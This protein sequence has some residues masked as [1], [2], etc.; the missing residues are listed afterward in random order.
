M[1]C[2]EVSVA[3]DGRRR[4]GRIQNIFFARLKVAPSC[5]ARTQGLSAF[6]LK[7][8]PRPFQA[9]ISRTNAR[10]RMAKVLA[11]W[12]PKQP[13]LCSFEQAL[14]T[15]SQDAWPAKGCGEAQIEQNGINVTASLANRFSK[16]GS[17]KNL[18]QQSAAAPFRCCQTFPTL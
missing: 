8:P 10:C 5:A 15:L 9:R 2:Y 18:A 7:F 3:Q 17:L 6:S 4:M 16:S 1:E 11:R 14:N 13:N 12:S